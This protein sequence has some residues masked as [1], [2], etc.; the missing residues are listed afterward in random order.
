MALRRLEVDVAEG[1]SVLLMQ[2]D[3][4][5]PARFEIAEA[6]LQTSSDGQDSTMIDL[7]NLPPDLK[8]VK[9]AVEL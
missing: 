6:S 3:S 7:V 5:K 9:L 4:S 2:R 8:R 1:I